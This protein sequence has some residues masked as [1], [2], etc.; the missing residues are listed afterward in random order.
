[1]MRHAQTVFLALMAAGFAACG[2]SLDK[3]DGR[4]GV[5]GGGG[6]ITSGGAGVVGGGGAP[7]AAGGGF[8]D[9]TQADSFRLRV[10]GQ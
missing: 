9:L 1:M 7:G 6:Q 5:G 2:G 3:G 8:S 4:G 10:R